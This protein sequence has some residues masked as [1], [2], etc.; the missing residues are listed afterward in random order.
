MILVD[1]YV[2]SV[3]QNFDFNLDEKA[4]IANVIEEVASLVTQR[5][6]CELKEDIEDLFL[7]DL[8]RSEILPKDRNLKQ[9]NITNGSHLIMV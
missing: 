7:C 6:H 9:C 2:P 8:Q 1:I 4:S 5:E 3:E